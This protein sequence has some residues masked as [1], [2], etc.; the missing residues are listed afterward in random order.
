MEKETL[1]Y[2]ALLDENNVVFHI[3]SRSPHGEDEE[4]GKTFPFDPSSFFAEFP[5]LSSI[6]EYSPNDDS[7]TQNKAEIGY[8]Y[9][10]T[11]NAFLP[12]K[13]D[14]TY[15]LNE[16]EFKWYPDPSLEYD[17]H[18]DGNLYKY[19]DPYWVPAPIKESEVVAE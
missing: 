15:L 5:E 4:T 1:L 19:E 16:E 9:D 8:T 10:S 12:P 13:P 14:E 17:L 7:I 18:G 6:K 3:A 11:L 2:F